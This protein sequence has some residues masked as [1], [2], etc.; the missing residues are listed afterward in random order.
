MKY[1]NYFRLVAVFSLALAIATSLWFASP[2]TLLYAQNGYGG[3]GGGGGGVRVPPGLTY[4]GG[5]ISGA[6]ILTEDVIAQSFDGL[7]QLTLSAGTK[8]VDNWGNILYW[9]IMLG[10][11]DLPTPPA[12]FSIIGHVYD[13]GPKGAIF[14]PALPLTLT[15]DPAFLPKGVPPQCLVIAMWDEATG[16]WVMLDSTV[17]PDTNTI[18]TYVSH[19]NFTVF[20]IL[21][22]TAPATFTV[23][24]LTIAPSKVS[25]GEKVTISAVVNNTGCCTEDYE[26]TLRINDVLRGTE[27]VTVP[28]R[29]SQ[30]VTFTTDEYLAGTYAVDVNGLGGAFVVSEASPPPTPPPPT[31]TPPAPTPTPHPPALPPAK[32]IN[33]WFI[34]SPIAGCIIIGLIIWLTARQRTVL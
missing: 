31:P 3:G 23:T 34:G 6:G 32:P 27:K 29:A 2:V 16:N 17:H 24:N 22:N 26:V 21:V 18:V 4:L 28:G 7:G 19:F 15:Y 10:T 1:K 25:I 13:F 14:A 12:G 33:W 5:R 30:K 8:V 11:R 20:A 9:I